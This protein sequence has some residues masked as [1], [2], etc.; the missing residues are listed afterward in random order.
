M[1]A[2]PERLPLLIVP[3]SGISVVACPKLAPHLFA[4]Y[5]TVWALSAKLAAANALSAFEISVQLGLSQRRKLPL[6]RV[7]PPRNARLLGRALDC[8]PN[9]IEVAFFGGALK[10]LHP[11]V[12]KQLR[13]CPACARLGHHF[14]IHQLCVFTTCPLHDLPLRECCPHCGVQINYDLGLSTVHGPINCPACYAPQLPVSRGGYPIA[15][16]VSP[17]TIRLIARWLAF[18][19]L[20]ASDPSLFKTAGVMNGVKIDPAFKNEQ[21][22]VL[23]PALSFAHSILPQFRSAWLDS[24]QS[25]SLEIVYWMH[26]KK[27]LLYC[28]EKSRK[29]YRRFLK[30]QSAELAPSPLILAFL[31]WRMTWQGSSNPY[32]LRRGH[33]LPLFGIAQWEA[34]QPAFDDID[35]GLHELSKALEA[36]WMNWIEC[37][38]LL[39]AKELDW[40][41]WRLR[42]HPRAFIKY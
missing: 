27:F 18:V 20:L 28:P 21:I 24:A 34:N 10:A 13:L 17:Q 37:V 39:K 5:E 26:A 36:S 16:T 15:G 14:I 23:R 31:Y 4:P 8:L 30:G 35:A 7:D 22:S 6:V 11:L 12:C 40:R 41:T 29:W 32:L 19:K 1:S 38:D 25:K 42:V 3:T 2:V 33:R 9:Q